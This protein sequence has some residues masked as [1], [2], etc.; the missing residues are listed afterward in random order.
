MTGCHC[1]LPPPWLFLALSAVFALGRA[2]TPC[3]SA[4]IADT[5]AAGTTRIVPTSPWL[6][7]HQ[8]QWQLVVQLVGCANMSPLPLL[9]CVSVTLDDLPTTSLTIAAWFRTDTVA[10]GSACLNADRHTHARAR[11]LLLVSAGSVAE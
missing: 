9:V 4:T 3:C 6:R 8:L 10:G 11:V 1:L 7:N 5:A 2:D